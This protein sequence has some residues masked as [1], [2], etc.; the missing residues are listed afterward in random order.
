LN[1]PRGCGRRSGIRDD[2]S[3]YKVTNVVDPRNSGNSSAGI[4]RP[5]AALTIGPFKSTEFY[6]NA[7]TGFHSNNALGTVL[8]YDVN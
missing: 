5:K 1:G 6:F 2:G 8:K 7:G 4:A 3:R